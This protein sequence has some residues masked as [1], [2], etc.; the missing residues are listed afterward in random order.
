[1]AVGIPPMA[2][3]GPVV[4]VCPE[5]F[6]CAARYMRSVVA[7][8][9]GCIWWIWGRMSSPVIAKGGVIPRGFPDGA[10]LDC[11]KRSIELDLKKP[12]D[13]E[14]FKKLVATADG[15]IEGFRPGVMERLGIGSEVCQAVNPKLVFGHMTGCQCS[16]WSQNSMRSSL[17]T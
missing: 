10:L 14:T 6:D 13:I 9:A 12:G 8:W 5:P 16:V 2:I 17:I 1:M 11:G 7:F 3:V 4:V 15:L